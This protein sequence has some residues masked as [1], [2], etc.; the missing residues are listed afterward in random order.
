MKNTFYHCLLAFVLLAVTCKQPDPTIQYSRLKR[1]DTKSILE[2]AK[3]KQFSYL[4]AKFVNSQGEKLNEE[5]RDLLDRGEMGKDY[6]VNHL[7][8]I[9]E[10]RV[11]PIKQED[12]FLESR[13]RGILSYQISDSLLVD[14]DCVNMKSSFEAEL[15][16]V[17]AIDTSLSD[18]LYFAARMQLSKKQQGFVASVLKNC[19]VPDRSVVGDADMETFL[20]VLRGNSSLVSLYFDDL[21]KASEEGK[22]D[23]K[24]WGIIQDNLLLVNRFPQIYGSQV[25]RDALYDLQDPDNVNQRR[26]PLGFRPIEEYLE[27]FGL[28]FEEEKK[29]MRKN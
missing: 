2:R 1:L 7:G 20:A 16:N 12:M 10:I 17:P 9:V 3:N 5:E 27:G 11:R 19:G 13:L 15:T 23:P 18:S 6:Y 26:L 29:R 28:N 14:V 25:W 4:Y 24:H 8:E 22:I 21:K